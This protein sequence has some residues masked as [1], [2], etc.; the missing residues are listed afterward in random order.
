ML[1][2]NKYLCRTTCIL[3]FLLSI[4]ITSPAQQINQYGLL[5][6]YSMKEYQAEIAGDSSKL[7]VEICREIPAIRLDIRYAT[8]NNFLGFPFYDTAVAF[9]RK[10]A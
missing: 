7:L 6:T 2:S 4:F 9:A 5:V 1:T 10:P 3:I 8:A